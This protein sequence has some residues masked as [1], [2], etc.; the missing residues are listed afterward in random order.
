MFRLKKPTVNRREFMKRAAVAGAALA[1]AYPS[2]PI[3]II[4]PY[5]AGGPADILVRAMGARL[6][7]AWDQ[8]VIVDNKPGANEIIAAEA[9]VSTRIY[10]RIPR[11]LLVIRPVIVPG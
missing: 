1:Q 4:V 5:T 6:T 3:H 7:D 2:R 10:S 9:T 11:S 8:P